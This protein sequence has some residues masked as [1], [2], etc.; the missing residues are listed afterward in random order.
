MLVCKE[1]KFCYLRPPRTATQSITRELSGRYGVHYPVSMDGSGHRTVWDLEFK[2]F[3]TFISVRNPFSRLV[4][5]WRRSQESPHR[6]QR[7]PDQSF[8][9]YVTD[10]DRG[11]REWACHSFTQ[12]PLI[13]RVVR[14]ESLAED[15]AAL[16]PKYFPRKIELVAHRGKSK[17]PKPW[18][19]E[20]DEETVEAVKK[21]WAVDFRVY[22]YSSKLEDAIS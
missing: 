17:Y 21:A 6:N 19:E 18:W 5:L 16:P 4:S 3:F 20:Y 2:G 22:G 12:A 15:L 1:F 8:R 11:W 10:E 13:S 14:Y 9:E 7:E